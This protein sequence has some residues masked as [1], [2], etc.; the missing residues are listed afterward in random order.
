M[1]KRCKVSALFEK[2]E[3]ISEDFVLYCIDKMSKDSE[4]TIQSSES[5]KN[6][7]TKVFYDLIF[8]TSSHYNLFYEELSRSTPI[9]DSMVRHGTEIQLK[10][11]KLKEVY[12]E[13]LKIKMINFK[14]IELYIEFV[15]KFVSQN[16]LD[17]D[18]ISRL[19]KLQQNIYF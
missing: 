18:D 17:K 7:I 16:A 14:M 5:N 4:I 6:A 2:T 13:L 9:I 10:I 19:S 3:S 11:G 8:E 12:A 1:G 15:S